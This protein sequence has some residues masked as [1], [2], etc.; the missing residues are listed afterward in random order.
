MSS[1]PGLPVPTPAADHHVHTLRSRGSVALGV[2][3][4]LA[5]LGLLVYSLDAGLVFVAA[6]LLVGVLAVVLFVRP[7]VR[8]SIE[9]VS[10]HNPFRHTFLPW[11]LVEDVASRWNLQVYSAGRVV[12]AWAISAHVE[13]PKAAVPFGLG[14]MGGRGNAAAWPT[15]PARAASGASVGPLTAQRAAG[16]IRAARDEWIAAVDDGVVVE[17]R[18]PEIARAWSMLDLGLVLAPLVLLVVGLVLS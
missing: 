8:L 16:L 7:C 18:R 15:E 12:S 9:G 4:A 10:V 17:P 6:M 13:R 3:A 14:W 5:C 2:V 11:R 1:D